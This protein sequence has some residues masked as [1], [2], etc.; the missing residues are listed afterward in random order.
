MAGGT[1]DEDMSLDYYMEQSYL[2][3]SWWL[4]NKGWRAMGD[5]LEAAVIRHFE[6]VNARTEL[7]VDQFDELIA[8]VI[9]DVN[10]NHQRQIIESIFPTSYDSLVETLINTNPD[11]IREL[12]QPESVFLKLVNETNFF[13]DDAMFLQ[14]FHRMVNHS[15]STLAN[16]LWVALDPDFLL[17]MEQHAKIAELDAPVKKF[18]LASFLAQVS[19]QNG[20][21]CDNNHLHE[22]YNEELAGNIYVNSLNELEELD[23]FSAGIYSNFE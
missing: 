23:E 22:D 11:L 18:K 21:I 1:V 8:L 2:S 17:T 16:N 14:I 9:K 20:I 15:R 5:V 6:A 7:T 13:V 4:L 3:L 19:V 10:S 12:D